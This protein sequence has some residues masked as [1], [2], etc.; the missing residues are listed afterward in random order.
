MYLTSYFFC[1]KLF[2][3]RKKYL[4]LTVIGFIL[5]NIFVLKESLATGNILFYGKPMRTIQQMFASDINTAFAID[6]LYIVVLFMIWSY[7]DSKKK[8]NNK[9]LFS[10]VWTMLF[11][12][13]SG[14]PLYFYL[15]AKDE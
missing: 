5:P 11:G 7:L 9:Y 1:H 3:M 10:A 13:A 6:L 14:L 12:L 2:D 15:Q 8:G 4:I